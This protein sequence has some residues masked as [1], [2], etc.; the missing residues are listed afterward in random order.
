MSFKISPFYN[1]TVGAQQQA[2]IGSGFVTQVPV[3]NFRSTGVELAFT[4]GDFTKNGLSGALSVTYTRA[5]QQ[6]TN[7]FQT[8]QLN[9]V[10]SVVDEFNKLTSAGGA[11]PYY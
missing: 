6:F 1:F 4:K 8:N 11:S 10:N 9:A 3:G 7:W 5:Q 2:F